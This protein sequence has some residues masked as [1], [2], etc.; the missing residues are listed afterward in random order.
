MDGTASRIRGGHRDQVGP[1]RHAVGWSSQHGALTYGV[2][3]STASA[4]FMDVARC[5]FL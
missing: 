4:L 2:R 5:I 3:K 1:V